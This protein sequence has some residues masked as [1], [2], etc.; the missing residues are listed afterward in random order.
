MVAWKAGGPSPSGTQIGSEGIRLCCDNGLLILIFL[1]ILISIL[2]GEGTATI[3]ITSRGRAPRMSRSVW[4]ARHPRAFGWDDLATSKARGCR[5]L[6]TLR[7]VRWPV[8]LC[9]HWVAG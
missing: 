6:Q 1:L 2:A 5:A 7:A 4:S 8:R 9:V 3:R